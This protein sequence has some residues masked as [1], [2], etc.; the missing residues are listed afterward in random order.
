[1]QKKKYLL[2]IQNKIAKL[3]LLPREGV[4]RGIIIGN[5]VA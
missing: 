5:K 3:L 2:N 4:T 1:L